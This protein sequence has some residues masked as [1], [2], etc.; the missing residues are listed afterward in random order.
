MAPVDERL[1]VALELQAAD[2]EAA[3][4][5]EHETH[6]HVGDRRR[7]VED[8][9]EQASPTRGRPAGDEIRNA[10][11]TPSGRPADVKPMNSGIDEHEQNGV[12]VPSRAASTMPRRSR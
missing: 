8:A 5:G 7:P 3:D 2:D 6:D 4:D 11:V 9:R 10:N 12:I 1:D